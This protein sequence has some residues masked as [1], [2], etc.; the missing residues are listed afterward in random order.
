[1]RKYLNGADFFKNHLAPRK[2]SPMTWNT[3]N[4]G[5]QKNLI[6][7]VD[8]L[9]GIS[10]DGSVEKEEE[11]VIQQI[12]EEFKQLKEKYADKKPERLDMDVAII[13]HK[14]LKK[15]KWGRFHI[16][17]FGM[18]RWISINYFLTEARWR[19]TS[20]DPKKEKLFEN[21]R[22]CYQRLVGERNR[23]IFPLWYFTI[24]ERLYDRHFGY[25]LLEKLA[26]KSRE[27]KTG[28]FGNLNNY[29]NDTKLL[30]PNEHVSKTMSRLLLTGDLLANNDEVE[31]SFK[32]YNAYKRRLL[33]YASDTIFENEIC[34][35]NSRKAS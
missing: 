30:S 20:E 23:R 29:L 7:V 6:D 31:D 3:F 26:V 11:E 16:E 21:A 8:K 2:E 19:W 22:S 18:W 24:G 33:N 1:M 15:L 17:D 25:S 9:P 32:R 5:N 10:I 34:L 28:G 14:N 35:T 4:I 27:K 13:F 12:K